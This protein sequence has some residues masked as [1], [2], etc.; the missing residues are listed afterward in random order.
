MQQSPLKMCA[1]MMLPAQIVQCVA[2]IFILSE[3]THFL[4]HPCLRRLILVTFS[5]DRPGRQ[6]PI[7][8]CQVS[9]TVRESVWPTVRH[10]CPSVS[11]NTTL[12]ENTTLRDN[13]TLKDNTTLR[14]NT[15]LRN[16]TT[17]RDNTT[18]HCYWLQHCS[19][20]RSERIKFCTEV[21]LRHSCPSVWD[22]TTLK[23]VFLALSCRELGK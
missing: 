12:R 21:S 23:C 6:P 15:T 11:D 4:R 9:V 16:N 8:E 5:F 10:S 22:N 13:I 17:L 14:E 19:N 7:C 1:W 18:V 3:R 2:T 20:D